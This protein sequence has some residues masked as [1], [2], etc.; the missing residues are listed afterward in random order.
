MQDWNAHS[1]GIRRAWRTQV[2]I[3][4]PQISKHLGLGGWLALP[5]CSEVQRSCDK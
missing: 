4:S 5:A 3:H 1:E 2:A